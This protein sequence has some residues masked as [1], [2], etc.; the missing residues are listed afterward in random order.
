MNKLL[1]TRALAT[2]VCAVTPFVSSAAQ[3][4]TPPRDTVLDTRLLPS[5]I[6]REVTEAFNSATTVR[7][8]GAYEIE[9]GRVIPGDVAVLNGPLTIAGRV[10][11]RVIAINSD[12]VLK[13]GA[14]VEG[15]ILV[16]GGDV[17]GK[18]NAFIGGDVRT[19]RQRLAYR[20]EGDHLIGSGSSE[21]DARWW[22]RRQKWRSS[23]YSQL[24][25]ISA[26]TYNRVEGLPILIGPSVGHRFGDGRF[27]IDALGV[28]RTGEH[29]DWNSRNIGH[30]VKTE[31]SFGHGPGLAIGGRLFDVVD[32]AE[33]WQLSD[34]E[35][36][37]ASFFLHRDFRDYYNRHGGSGYVRLALSRSV[38]LTASLSDERWASR[39]TLDPYTLFRNSQDWRP[40]PALDEAKL[41]IANGRLR[42]D[43]RT[44]DDDPRSGW[45]ITA[46]YER[47]TGHIT[48]FA[49]TSPG[50]RDVGLDGATTY[51][52]GFLDLRRYNRLSPEG[53]LNFRVVAGGWLNGDELPL[54]R[55]FSLGGPGAL[56]GY[57]F[58]RTG[59]G[60]DVRQCSDGV[61]IPLGM[62]AQCERM[63]LL[64]AEY[65]GDLWMSL[66]GDF[67]FNDSWRG[68]GWE[69]R[70][71][72][73]IFTDAG[74]GWLVGDRLGELRYP[75][76]Q[77]PS[78]GT[79]KTDIGIG[80]DAGLIGL[81]LAKSVSD[82]KE[83]PN[84]FVRV[85]RRF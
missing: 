31:L 53:Q 26:K 83:P 32:P 63:V 2:L 4:V 80:F 50:V 69:R 73:V 78:L 6:E 37:L 14:R 84:F 76:D 64:Q 46:D 45:K 58:R 43:T 74:R 21:E 13:P 54:Q 38:D 79:F 11:G 81:Y 23:S 66:F 19:Y 62:P 61:S 60:E 9:A 28:F 16:V 47:G 18:D 34:T 49:P 55:R 68:S 36:G 56:D 40:N 42:V 15:Q 72:W 22:R 3:Q 35:V 17:E 59:S 5:E 65:R 24:R 51:A 85:R 39:Q 1:A 41:H 82:S 33:E 10:N 7:A 12:V 30:S 70:A 29:V 27:E 48:Q 8:T 71:Q 77:L 25:L 67:D 57:P 20:R 52:R 75:K 44:D